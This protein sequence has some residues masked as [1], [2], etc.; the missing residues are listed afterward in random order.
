MT[1]PDHGRPPQPPRLP[2]PRAPRIPAAGAIPESK[3]AM[4]DTIEYDPVNKRLL[5]GQ[6]YVENVEPGMWN[7]EV[8]GKQILLV[9]LPQG[10][11]GT[12][13]DRR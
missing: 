2:A 12:S 10:K 1:D 6:G 11:Q 8:S 5:V 3:E 4:P 13:V 9:Q 7:Y